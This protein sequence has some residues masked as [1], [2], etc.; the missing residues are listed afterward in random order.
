M[1]ARL[2]PSAEKWRAATG[3]L[4]EDM[5]SSILIGGTTFDAVS[6]P[7]EI[8]KGERSSTVI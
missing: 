5:N 8:N 3:W 1:T 7:A 4:R 2:V 6:F